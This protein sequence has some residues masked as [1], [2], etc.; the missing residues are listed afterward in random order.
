M[1]LKWGYQDHGHYFG[2]VC[3]LL[4]MVFMIQATYQCHQG[5]CISNR[6]ENVSP[7]ELELHQ[8]LAEED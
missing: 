8:S 6:K 1:L 7:S 3:L 4:V 5:A 2:I